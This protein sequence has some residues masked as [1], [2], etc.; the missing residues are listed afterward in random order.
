MIFGKK[1]NRKFENG[2]NIFKTQFSSRAVD[3]LDNPNVII[4]NG[5]SARLLPVMREY[6]KRPHGSVTLL[7][8]ARVA[9]AHGVHYCL[10]TLAGGSASCGEGLASRP[11][12]PV[13]PIPRGPR[14]RSRFARPGHTS[15]RVC[16][17]RGYKNGCTA[18]SPSRT[19]PAPQTAATAAAAHL[20]ATAT[21]PTAAV[22]ATGAVTAVH[23]LTGRRRRPMNNVP[24]AHHEQPPVS[25]GH[26]V[27]PRT[28]RRRP[29]SAGTVVVRI[30]TAP[31]EHP[32]NRQTGN[33]PI[34]L[35]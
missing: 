11:R 34:I 15:A 28:A 24:G 30:A 3:R 14:F 33:I 19:G 9:P 7:I 4:H 29:M 26:A 1:K 8:G 32:T 23:Q 25:V 6:E 22:A 27:R 17:G 31:T 16:P 5:Y 12:R 20:A 10:R 35:Y 21:T 18:P 2:C 13:I